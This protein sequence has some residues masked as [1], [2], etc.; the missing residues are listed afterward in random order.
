M[1]KEI[2]VA[3]ERLRS[4]EKEYAALGLQ[5]ND[6]L[7]RLEVRRRSQDNSWGLEQEDIELLAVLSILPWYEHT[8]VVSSSALNG[9]D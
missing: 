2:N 8:K 4:F 1:R 9:T 7:G 5:I 6:P 3:S